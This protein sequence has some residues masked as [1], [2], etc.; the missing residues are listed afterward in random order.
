MA[1]A[2]RRARRA[3]E[4]SILSAILDERMLGEACEDSR[5]RYRKDNQQRPVLILCRSDAELRNG[6]GPL[7][8]ARIA[9][10]WNV[11]VSVY[12]AAFDIMSK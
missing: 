6:V 11:A 9:T 12:S 5:M 8:S 2:G 7:R 10:L 1:N 4:E 3:R